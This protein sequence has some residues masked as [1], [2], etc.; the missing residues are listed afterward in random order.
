MKIPNRLFVVPTIL[1]A[2]FLSVQLSL[3]AVSTPVITGNIQYVCDGGSVVL[4][5]LPNGTGTYQNGTVFQWFKEGSL[6]LNATTSTYTT[7]DYGSYSV[8]AIYNAEESMSSSFWVGT[9]KEAL[10]ISIQ[11][12]KGS[13]KMTF[14]PTNVTPNKIVNTRLSYGISARWANAWH[15]EVPQVTSINAK[16][17]FT[18]PAN[19]STNA[20]RFRLIYTNTLDGNYEMVYSSNGQSPL[21]PQ[22]IHNNQI[23]FSIANGSALLGLATGYYTLGIA[24]STSFRLEDPG[25]LICYEGFDNETAYGWMGEWTHVASPVQN[26]FFIYPASSSPLEYDPMPGKYFKLK[27]S[28][29]YMQLKELPASARTFDPT[30]FSEYMH[31]GRV[32]KPGKTIWASFLIRKENNND[33]PN[34]VVL[35]K[36][37]TSSSELNPAIKIGYFSN[38]EDGTRKLSLQLAEGT[39]VKSVKEFVPGKNYLLVAR[40]EF[41]AT[42]SKVTV[43]INPQSFGTWDPNYYEDKIE[44]FTSND[45]SFKHLLLK[46][47]NSASQSSFDEIRVGK[48]YP[49]VSPY[50]RPV[51]PENNYNYITT[52]NP[53]VPV[54]EE[55]QV[56]LLDPEEVSVVTSYYDVNGQEIQKVLKNAASDLSDIV[57]K[58]EYNQST[59]QTKSYLPFTT[60]VATGAY[61]ETNE[62]FASIEKQYKVY[63]FSHD[64]SNDPASLSA[65]FQGA[66]SAPFYSEKILD[67]ESPSKKIEMGSPGDTWKIGAKSIRKQTLTNGENEVLYFLF[68]DVSLNASARI[69]DGQLHYYLPGDMVVDETIEENGNII[70]NFSNRQGQLILKKALGAHNETPLETYYIYD[71]FGRLRYMVPPKAVAML[72]AHQWNISY[73]DPL[74]KQLIQAT[75]YNQLGQIVESS[76]P[77]AAP[78]RVMYDK[79]GR[80]I[81]S[82]DGNQKAKSEWSVT[83]YDEWNRV[84]MT[85]ISSL[86]GDVEASVNNSVELHESPA[87]EAGGN[88]GY[89]RIVYPAIEKVLT[90]NYYDDYDFDNDGIPDYDYQYAQ[91]GE[92]EPIPNLSA[93]GQLTGSKTKL[94]S[95]SNAFI[96]TVKFFDQY[97]FNIQNQR[98]NTTNLAH[99]KDVR[100]TVFDFTGRTI[101]YKLVHTPSA[102]YGAPITIQRRYVYDHTGKMVRT[103]GSFNDQQEVLLVGHKYTRMGRLKEKNIHSSDGGNSYL[104]SIDYRYNVR[105]WLTSINNAELSNDGKTNDDDNDLFGMEL[106]YEQAVPGLNNVPSYNG[107]IS[108]QL[109][110]TKKPDN[111]NKLA[112][113]YSYDYLNRLTSGVLA[114]FNTTW[115]SAGK[116]KEEVSAYDA[117]GNILSIS[118]TNNGIQGGLPMDRMAYDYAGNRL[119]AINETGDSLSGYVDQHAGNDYSYDDNGNQITMWAKNITDVTYNYLNQPTKYTLSTG[120][121]QS[122]DYLA[123]GLLIKRTTYFNNSVVKQTEFVDQFVYEDQVLAYIAIENGRA[124]PDGAGGFRYEYDLTDHLGNVRATF[125]ADPLDNK[126]ARVVQVQHYY[127]FGA[128]LEAYQFSLGAIQLYQFAGREYQRDVDFDLKL[129]DFGARQYDPFVGRWSTLDHVQGECSPYSYSFNNPIFYKDPDGNWPDPFLSLAQRMEAMYLNATVPEGYQISVNAPYSDAITKVTMLPEVVVTPRGYWLEDYMGYELK[130]LTFTQQVMVLSDRFEAQARDFLTPTAEFIANTLPTTAVFNITSGI[131]NGS[132]LFE[133]KMSG[134]DYGLNT[135]SVLPFGTILSKSWNVV[136]GSNLALG[137]GDD[138]FKFANSKGFD[139]YRSFSTGF[140]KDKILE[141]LN[142]YDNIHFNITDFSRYKFS[143]FDPLSPLT[144]R[145]YTNWEMYTIFNDPNLLSK[146]TFYRNSGRGYEI[147]FD[148]SPYFK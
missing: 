69:G 122:R 6:I 128:K 105:G 11:K 100:T 104:Q 72:A 20:R 124:I 63:G 141:A 65:N 139:T 99:V 103:Y 37:A 140:Q 87:I 102:T 33:D 145:N 106:R 1:S 25:D 112:Y 107:N 74:G 56:E 117:N 91:F 129:I 148:Y 95:S 17:V 13:S 28:G 10:A 66:F 118:R 93:T 121:S 79:L 48:N 34:Y 108:A 38:A 90:V 12:M 3:A 40:I 101:K 59:F 46:G 134:F 86:E 54:L 126:L 53:L 146:T 73:D 96:T 83:K 45:I 26:G 70:R 57:Y 35:H 8:K 68:D 21:E 109:W 64:Y 50:V 44:A 19:T 123:D 5:A 62:L 92:D 82:Q 58:S 49:S 39:E 113:S 67:G 137:L 22:I 116:N 51:E 125:D 110:K 31:I 27:Q 111:T 52:I 98:N 135:A 32:G 115:V 55:S 71:T 81:L 84:V 9:C 132:D 119:V 77:G 78:V 14:A 89:S 114:E 80:K 133:N 85:G 120:Y 42:K 142:S 24:S 23:S 43:Y 61:Q 36:N 88:M 47:G 144:Y 131:M 30:Y 18:L 130:D 4:T 97:G 15:V 7:K 76:H 143:K 16:L 60:G 138:L 94:L 2:L 29:G 41:G 136:R 127:P 75:K 147:I